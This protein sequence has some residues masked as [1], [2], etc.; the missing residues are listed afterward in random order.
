MYVYTAMSMFCDCKSEKPF[1][2]LSE[3]ST[4]VTRTTP[5]LFAAQVRVHRR[6]LYRRSRLIQGIFFIFYFLFVAKPLK[7]I[8]L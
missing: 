2:A 4:V 8:C 5:Y 7:R 6:R 3:T 1:K